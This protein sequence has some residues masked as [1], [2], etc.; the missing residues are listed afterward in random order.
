VWIGIAS[1]VVVFAMT[2]YTAHEGYW[3]ANFNDRAPTSIDGAWEVEGKH[4][5]TVPSWVSFEYNR[6]YMVVLRFADGISGCNPFRGIWDLARTS[7]DTSARNRACDGGDQ[8]GPCSCRGASICSFRTGLGAAEK[9]RDHGTRART[10]GFDRGWVS[11]REVITQLSILGTPSRRAVP[12][13]S[14]VRSLP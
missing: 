10:S 7:V 14:I 8:G 4:D 5:A 2:A 13:C 11:N 12:V 1:A 6:A 3:L 9:L